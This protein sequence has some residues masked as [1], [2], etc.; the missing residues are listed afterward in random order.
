MQIFDGVE[1]ADGA[2]VSTFAAKLSGSFDYVLHNAG[3]ANWESNQKVAGEL[4]EADFASFEEVCPA[5]R[6]D[7]ATFSAAG[8]GSNAIARARLL[9]SCAACTRA[10]QPEL[11]SLSCAARQ[12][13]KVNGIAPVRMLNTLLRTGALAEGSKMGFLTSR[14][15]SM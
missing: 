15:G 3:I 10:A 1:V 9:P 8:A 2:S 7:F 13:W 11:R 6:A 4:D 14:M 12:E 5:P